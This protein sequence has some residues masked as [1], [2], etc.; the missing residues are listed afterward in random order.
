[1]SMQ[2]SDRLLLLAKVLVEEIQILKAGGGLI[3]EEVP[4][5]RFIVNFEFEG[6]RITGISKDTE[7]VKKNEFGRYN[8]SISELSRKVIERLTISEYGACLE[9][10]SESDGVAQP[11]AATILHQF[12][13]GLAFKIV[14]ENNTSDTYLKELIAKFVDE[15]GTKPDWKII[16]WLNGVWVDQSQ[17]K[18]VEGVILRQPIPTDF[19]VEVPLSFLPYHNR[20]I[21]EFSVTAV[22]EIS[23]RET[24]YS[25]VSSEIG[26]YRH[27]LKLFRL[28]QI[29]L[30]KHT[31][32]PSRLTGST[33]G[34]A[35]TSSAIVL[36]RYEYEFRQTDVDA[37]AQYCEHIRA[38]FRKERHRNLRV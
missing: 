1:V 35:I 26:N 9:G 36:S 24:P 29:T 38:C 4:Y 34:T 7:E 32:A 16:I 2:L 27:L 19:A 12:I 8:R 23:L 33:Y 31:L 6:G 13:T 10:I 20:D 37:F 14:N 15:L 28:G 30:L 11:E 17:I 3:P 18:I 21:E 25:H 5:V 22:L